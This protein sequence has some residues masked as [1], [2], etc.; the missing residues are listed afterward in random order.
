MCSAGVHPEPGLHLGMGSGTKSVSGEWRNGGGGGLEGGLNEAS[1]HS[2][3]VR[4]RQ[5]S[6][7]DES[8]EEMDDSIWKSFGWARCGWETWEEKENGGETRDDG[9]R[10]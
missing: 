3:A 9:H 7:V 1:S 2:M 5:G 10:T 6:T 4:G 8:L